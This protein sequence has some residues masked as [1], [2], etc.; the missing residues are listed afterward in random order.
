MQFLLILILTCGGAVILYWVL[1]WLIERYYRIRL[2]HQCEHEQK[3]ILTFDDGPGNRL[4][5]QLLDLLRKHKVRATFFLLGRNIAGR[6]KWVRKIA[7]EGH[8]I[9]SHSYDHLNAWT[10]PPWRVIADI[11]QGMQEIDKALGAN[12]KNY[13]F[14]PPHGKLNLFSLLYLWIC[15]TPIY[16]W[17]LDGGDTWRP[18]ERPAARSRVQ[19]LMKGGVILL[20][21]FDRRSGSLQTDQFV[22]ETVKY[23]LEMAN[24]SGFEVVTYSELAS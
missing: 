9:C 19:F 16:Y 2:K 11:R 17:T 6:E 3:I 15:R 23:S 18:E 22:L 4:T 24:S 12:N 21:D 20:H 13:P 1:P 14:R 5:P 7:A 10:T 8:E